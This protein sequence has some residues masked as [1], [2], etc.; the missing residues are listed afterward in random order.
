[1]KVLIAGAL[2][3]ACVVMAGLQI[4]SLVDV[5]NDVTRARSRATAI[6]DRYGQQDLGQR[7]APEIEDLGDY[8]RT[9]SSLGPGRLI[10][11][12]DLVR[13]AETIERG[14]AEAQPHAIAL[15]VFSGLA[16]I[17]TIVLLVLLRRR[18]RGTPA[19]LPQS[20]LA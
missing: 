15:A 1:M 16:V 20:T 4:S 5:R 10:H 8:L 2:T 14:E 18:P 12:G 3:L 11:A 9:T 13:A 17:F 7:T 19:N 6:G